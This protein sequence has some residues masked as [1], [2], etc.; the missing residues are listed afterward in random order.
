MSAKSSGSRADAAEVAHASY[1]QEMPLS[2][3]I[4][5][6][7]LRIVASNRRFR[8]HF[9]VGIGSYCWATCRGQDN[10][11]PRCLVQETFRAGSSQ[12]GQETFYDTTGR[13]MRVIV[14]TAPI[15]DSSGKTVQVI[16]TSTDISELQNLQ[17]DLPPTQRHLQ[18]LFD[19]VPCYITVHDRNFNVC[20]ANRRFKE[21]F[22]ERLNIPCY[23]AYKR[24]TKPCPSCPVAMTFE[25]GRTH[26]AEELVTSVSGHKYHL[27]AQTASI[28]DA[29]GETTHVVQTSIDITA[30]K[31]L[32]DRSTSLGLL[33]SSISFTHEIKRVLS[34]LDGGIYIMNSGFER[35]DH[36]RL[37]DGW[38]IVQRTTS[39]L[40][41]MVLH[42]LYHAKD[43]ELQFSTI[44][45]A[46]FTEDIL[47][48]VQYRADALGVQL[49]RNLDL[50][51]GDF[52]ADQT[53]LRVALINILENALDPQRID[54]GKNTHRVS[55]ELSCSGDDVT[56]AVLDNGIGM[57]KETRDKVS[58]LFLWSQG[59]GGTG[60][61]L[62]I[63]NKIVRQ[64]GGSLSLSSTL[65]VGS[66]FTVTIPRRQDRNQPMRPRPPAHD[67]LEHPLQARS[68]KPEPGQP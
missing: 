26:T 48:K 30:L 17:H 55:F 49:D 41:N 39:Q 28:R 14:R 45:A 15:R 6:P 5:D 44:D 64:H 18:Q 68:A 57:D 47:D 54:N 53:A 60:L 38:D 24:Q 20:Q 22:G 50:S 8:E 10:E 31:Q 37:Q 36:D 40:R 4:L 3:I 42:V 67:Q 46:R 19:E 65:G 21:R 51:A 59:T 13:E 2:V 52:E 29:D 61:G 62:F 34:T 25:D 16:Q 32:Q 33:M 43:R 56:F 1:F 7:D 35:D 66:S 27:L 9:G 11:C 23:E 12:I 63:S 58:S